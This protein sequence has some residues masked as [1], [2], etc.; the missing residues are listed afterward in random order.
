MCLDLPPRIRPLA[1]ELDC[2]RKHSKCL[3]TRVRWA[4]TM[5]AVKTM[6]SQSIAVGTDT[7]T[8]DEIQAEIIVARNLD[9]LE[10][11][12]GR[13]RSGGEFAISVCRPGQIWNDRFVQPCVAL[14]LASFN[15]FSDVLRRP[16]FPFHDE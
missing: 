9:G 6:Q 7:L 4:R 2:P 11:R 13:K 14:T 3:C 5:A 16:K 1:V 10:S 8:P 12:G 15:E